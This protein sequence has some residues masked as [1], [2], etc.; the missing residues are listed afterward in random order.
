MAVICHWLSHHFPV[1]DG[2]MSIVT[3]SEPT[4]WLAF[5]GL[6]LLI[7]VW[8][9]SWMFDECFLISDPGYTATWHCWR[10]LPKVTFDLL[11]ICE[12]FLMTRCI[13]ILPAE[14]HLGCMIG[15][16]VHLLSILG[17]TCRSMICPLWR[18]LTRNK[19]H[20]MN[21]MTSSIST[22]RTWSRPDS[23]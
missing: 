4:F 7:E 11:P 17:A 23:P 8:L 15:E 1:N 6:W 18:G 5:F 21:Q 2:A 22:H 19:R 13:A 14:E 20:W 10:W 3:L 9:P 12:T 16:K